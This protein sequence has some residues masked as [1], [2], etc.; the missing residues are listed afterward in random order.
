[1]NAVVIGASTGGPSAVEKIIVDLPKGLD[2]VYIVAQH[3]PGYISETYCTR[4]NKLCKMPV[5]Y[6]Q[7]NKPLETDTI[8]I[9]PGDY[10]FLISGENTIYLL[11]A[12]TTLSPSI[13]M[14][15][16]T[17]AEKFGHKTLG[18]ILTGMGEDG[19]LGCKAIKYLGGHVIAQDKE[20]STIYGMPKEVMLAGY[21][22]EILPL[23]KIA[24]RIIEILK[25]HEL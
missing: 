18:V 2:T 23:D 21:A 6:M 5:V 13:D 4:L 8:Y 15:F 14:A 19:T 1:M 22:N 9:I 7:H 20:S 12:T 11:E 17:I 3:L 25:K 24:E 10:H 16:T